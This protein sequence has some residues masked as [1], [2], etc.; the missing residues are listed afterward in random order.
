MSSI[1]PLRNIYIT[2]CTT[3][4]PLNP[5]AAWPAFSAKAS[6]S[7]P[8]GSCLGIDFVITAFSSDK[9]S[10]DFAEINYSGFLMTNFNESLC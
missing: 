7:T 2:S 9:L 4:S 5:F 3:M 6:P 1:D 8:L 10:P